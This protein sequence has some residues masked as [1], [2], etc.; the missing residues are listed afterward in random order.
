MRDGIAVHNGGG[1]QFLVSGKVNF[2]SHHAALLFDA[3]PPLI[4]VPG[5]SPQAAVLR[6]ALEQLASEL[7]SPGPGGALVSTH[8]VHLML[9]QILRIHL[10]ALSCGAPAGWLSALADPRIG[11]ALGAIH[12]EPGRGWTLEA[13]AR[14]AGV[15]RT[16]FA[17]RF[18]ALA[19]TTVM[20]YLTRW[21]M[22]TA[23]GTA[24]QRRREHFRHR[25][26][27]GL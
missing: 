3:L 25:V 23:A 10:G 17:Q 6:W 8:L 24:A 14:V 27:A 19:G 20:N 7:R 12:A 16:V 21:R 15:S 26:F 11:A 18:K 22:H 9:V 4:K 5:A 1:E 13:L 2:D